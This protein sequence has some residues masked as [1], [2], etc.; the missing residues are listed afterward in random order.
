MFVSIYVCVSACVQNIYLYIVF[1]IFKIYIHLFSYECSNNLFLALFQFIHSYVCYTLG[2]CVSQFDSQLGFKFRSTR[3][4]FCS[5]F[6][7]QFNSLSTPICWRDKPKKKR[8][9]QL[10]KKHIGQSKYYNSL[11]PAQENW[12]YFILPRIL[13][14]DVPSQ[15]GEIIRKYIQDLQS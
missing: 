7:L 8:L 5:S 12:T 9:N 6:C 11:L 2:L 15:K 4:T 14:H 13:D 3:E 1:S 10:R